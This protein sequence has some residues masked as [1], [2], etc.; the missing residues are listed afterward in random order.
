M[1]TR[2]QSAWR[3]PTLAF[4]RAITALVVGSALLLAPTAVSAG[5]YTVA[6]NGDPVAHGFAPKTD[7][8]APCA[9]PGAAASAQA[10]TIPSFGA[11]FF[12]FNAPGSASI[13]SAH[14]VGRFNKASSSE[15]LCAQSFADV[16]SPLPLNLCTGGDFDQIIPIASGRWF[17][18]GLR[19]K[20]NAP[21]GISSANANNVNLAAGAISLDDPSA[22]AA[23][24]AGQ[25]PA[26]VTGDAVSLTWSATDPESSIA[27]ASYQTDGAPPIG[28]LGDGCQDVYVCGVTRGGAFTVSG[29]SQAPDGPH[30]ITL[31]AASAGGTASAAM[32]FAT[33][34]TPPAFIGDP[35]YPTLI[36]HHQLV[37]LRPDERRCQHR[38]DTRRHQSNAHALTERGGDLAGDDDS[39]D[40][41]RVRLSD[42]HGNH[43]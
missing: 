11:C 7:A 22:P 39:P 16:G 41:Q 42:A 26:W 30:A 25:I 32:Q 20:F 6:W 15:N 33:D 19:N 3:E 14:V 29:L 4:Y 5:P 8:G 17:E 37:S 40:R 1:H 34:H 2:Q 35:S 18:V 10:G 38:R 12:I 24:L 9:Y 23:S 36:A 28:L 27:A 13:T 31:S 21:I 43:P